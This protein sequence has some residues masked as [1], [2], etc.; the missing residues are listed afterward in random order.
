[1]PGFGYFDASEYEPKEDSTAWIV[2]GVLP[3]NAFGFVAG[4]AKGASSPFGGKSVMERHLALSVITGEPFFGAKVIESGRVMF[5]NLDEDEEKQV[6]LYYR[7]TKG[8]KVPGFLIS[9]AKACKLPAQAKLLEEDIKEAKPLVCIIDPL[10]RVM[11][12]KKVNEQADVGPII[13]ELKRISKEQACTIIVN[14]HSNKSGE[15][16]KDTTAS[17]L[18][19][20][21]DLDAAWDFCL[22]LE[23]EKASHAVHLRNFQK[24]KALTSIYYEAELVNGDEIVGLY[25]IDPEMATSPRAREVYSVA[26]ANP[27][28][29]VKWL[30]EKTGVSRTTL[31][32]YKQKFRGFENIIWN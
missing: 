27:G 25:H 5:V 31:Y 18:S 16:D 32:E 12:G 6:R 1:M 7:M 8:A 2:D 26:I 3:R 30:S 21:N 14:H 20:S 23:Y 13:D 9:R 24:E 15:R 29:S 19:G 22:C 4:P 10:Q 28:K 11:G 17:W